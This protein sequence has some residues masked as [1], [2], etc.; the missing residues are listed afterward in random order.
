MH[1]EQANIVEDVEEV[2]PLLTI[3]ALTAAVVEE[4]QR[5]CVKRLVATDQR[6]CDGHL[7]S[8]MKM[9]T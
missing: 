2:K 5:G 1:I 6:V 3:H 9:R 8:V 7:I 4:T